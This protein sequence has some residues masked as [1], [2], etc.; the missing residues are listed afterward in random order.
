MST[1]RAL[2]AVVALVL[3]GSAGWLAGWSARGGPD[4]PARSELTGGLV[5]ATARGVAAIAA[6]HVELALEGVH[7]DPRSRRDPTCPG[8]R[9]LPIELDYRGA[10]V[11][12]DLVVG[13]CRG[14][15]RWGSYCRRP[16]HPRLV[17]IEG[18]P[19]GTELRF[20]RALGLDDGTEVHAG[21]T[22]THQEGRYRVAQ[23]YGEG[24]R[25]A[26]SHRTDQDV[27]I[28]MA[29]LVAAVSDRALAPSIDAAYVAA[30]RDLP[31][32]GER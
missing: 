31:S 4:R 15:D 25:L 20:C 9:R 3:A 7:V 5:P 30:G 24:W 13:R 18:P 26:V 23:R 21:V 14:D 28:P 2:A 12:L 17:G 8:H 6:P 32:G 1:R 29:Q 11:H 10:D 22:V 19:R 27:R 16:P